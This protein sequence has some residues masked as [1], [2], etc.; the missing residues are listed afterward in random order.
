MYRCEGLLPH[1]GAC[2]CFTRFSSWF[3][4][5]FWLPIQRLGFYSGLAFLA[6]IERGR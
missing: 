4:A 5:C 6:A 3:H 1:G 2:D